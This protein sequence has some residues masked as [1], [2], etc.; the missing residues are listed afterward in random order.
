MFVGAIA[1]YSVMSYKSGAIGIGL[2]IVA[3]AALLIGLSFVITG[4]IQPAFLGPGM[5]AALGIGI[6]LR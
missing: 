3:S 5:G 2:S 1:A 4:T 6:Y